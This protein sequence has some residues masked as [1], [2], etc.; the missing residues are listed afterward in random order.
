MIAV[1][2]SQRHVCRA[3][4]SKPGV[5]VPATRAFLRGE[6][7][8]GTSRAASGL[9]ALFA[10][11]LAYCRTLWLALC[12]VRKTSHCHALLVWRCFSC[13]PACLLRTWRDVWLAVSQC[14]VF[15]PVPVP[16]CQGKLTINVRPPFTGNSIAGHPT[17]APVLVAASK[18]GSTFVLPLTARS[19]LSCLSRQSRRSFLTAYANKQGLSWLNKMYLE[20]FR[21]GN[22]ATDNRLKQAHRVNL[23]CCC[24]VRRRVRFERSQS[25]T[26]SG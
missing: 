21:T 13:V 26:M 8:S 20:G 22:R 7:T 12:P 3:Y 14:V 18:P 25:N 2:Q 16:M 5:L 15:V 17:S 10:R 23:M 24:T 4:A 1:C 9:S 6:A 19:V 11:S